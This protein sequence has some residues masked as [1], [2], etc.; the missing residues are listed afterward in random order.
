MKYIT[1]FF[2]S[3]LLISCNQKK[4]SVVAKDDENKKSDTLEKIDID[5]TLYS[6]YDLS[7]KTTAIVVNLN[8]EGTYK[9][10]EF[11]KTFND[12]NAKDSLFNVVENPK[13][14]KMRNFE[15]YDTLGTY[16]L[17]RNKTLENQ[18][19]KIIQTS[20]YVYGT[21]GFS[22]ITINN[23]VCGL[24]EC[25]TN[26]IAF[27]IENFDVAKN[28]KPIFCSKQLLAI[29]YQNSYFDI[30]KKVRDYDDQQSKNYDYKDNIKTK[31]FAN[32]G[33]AYFSYNDDFM[34]G[35][36]HGKSKCDFPGRAIYIVTKNKP[37]T[38]FWV[39]GLDLFGIP[40]D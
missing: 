39:D 20:Y 30:Q 27:P 10:A 11:D 6:V 21:K 34:W 32:L 26:I 23:V 29:N 28:G 5:K 14:H 16:K 18:I 40:C 35:K 19:K 1:G 12:V 2:L 36:D 31:I 25:R 13:T 38:K 3:L 22:K 7:R 33:D 9:G 8:E 24:D 37:I 4:E 15:Y 17:I